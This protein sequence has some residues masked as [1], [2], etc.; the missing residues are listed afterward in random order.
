MVFPIEAG[1]AKLRITSYA[2]PL[3]WAP[4]GHPAKQPNGQTAKWPNGQAAKRPSSQTVKNSN[5]QTANQPSCQ[6]AKQPNGQTAK[7]PNGQT[8]NRP[9]CQTAK[10]PNNYFERSQACWPVRFGLLACCHTGQLAYKHRDAR[11]PG[12]KTAGGRSCADQIHSATQIN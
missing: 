7:L 3:I 9:S 6:A 12:C 5:G 10:L 4:N 2:V 1:F 11:L 8:A